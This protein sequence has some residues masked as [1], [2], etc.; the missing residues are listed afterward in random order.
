MLGYSKVDGESDLFEHTDGT[1]IYARTTNAVQFVPLLKTQTE[2]FTDFLDR[3]IAGYEFVAN[4][5]LY[6]TT[7]MN[8]YRAGLAISPSDINTNGNVYLNGSVVDGRASPQ[9]FY[10]N[11]NG[12]Y[13]FGE[14]E[15]SNPGNA[16]SGLG[17]LII[18]NY[19]PSSNFPRPVIFNDVNVYDQAVEQNPP[20]KLTGPPEQIHEDNL[21]RRSSGTIASYG[22]GQGIMAIG[23]S[24]KTGMLY[25]VFR[26]DG[27]S[28]EAEPLSAIEH[29]RHLQCDNA[30]FLDGSTSITARTK[31]GYYATPSGRKNNSIEVGFGLV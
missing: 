9:G 8:R 15:P 14:G 17:P 26:E 6:S 7:R 4:G 21:E 10:I 18:Q 13:Q 29:F 28:R 22:N 27:A 23:T 30:V 24:S 19:R 11:Y 25:V 3:E 2:K 1:Y 20:P 12:G 5:P 16:F 31:S